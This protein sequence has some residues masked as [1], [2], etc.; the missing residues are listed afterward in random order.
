STKR[1]KGKK[2]TG[3]TQDLDK[4]AA[5][6]TAAATDTPVMSPAE[7]AAQEAL[8]VGTTRRVDD[9]EASA[10]S[11]AV[12]VEEEQ[13]ADISIAPELVDSLF[14]ADKDEGNDASNYE[15]DGYVKPDDPEATDD[16]LMIGT[17]ATLPADESASLL[18]DADEVVDNAS[19]G[20]E[21]FVTA[22]ST[23]EAKADYKVQEG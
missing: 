7:A 20:E 22:A 23:A 13:G 15:A 21:E 8:S 16:D 4:N 6:A 11:S 14:V 17:A 1:K 12:A 10:S 2:R 9:Q 18:S 5:A 19:F 3:K